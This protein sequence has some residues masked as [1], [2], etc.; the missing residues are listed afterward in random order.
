MTQETKR[1]QIVINHDDALSEAEQYWYDFITEIEA[2]PKITTAVFDKYVMHNWYEDCIKPSSPQDIKDLRN[3]LHQAQFMLLQSEYLLQ[4]DLDDSFQ[5]SALI[6]NDELLANVDKDG[7]VLFAVTLQLLLNHQH[8]ADLFTTKALSSVIEIINRLPLVMAFYLFKVMVQVITNIENGKF[9]L[10]AL[11][12]FAEKSGLKNAS[13]EALRS[14][15]SWILS[16]QFNAAKN[17][18]T[19]S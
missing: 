19:A 13:F 17:R 11:L 14:Y 2:L 1:L 10:V 7:N 5:A 4:I 18:F 6:I 15:Y 3:M 8:E 12:V 16:L 9:Q